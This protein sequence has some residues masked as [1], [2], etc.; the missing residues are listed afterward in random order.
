MLCFFKGAANIRIVYLPLLGIKVMQN[1]SKQAVLNF[2]VG[3]KKPKQF[4]R[5]KIKLKYFLFN[6]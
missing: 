4:S 1:S 3:E 2:K 6:F 5:S